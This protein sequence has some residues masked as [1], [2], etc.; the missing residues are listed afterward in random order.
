MSS[1]GPLIDAEDLRKNVNGVVLGSMPES[2]TWDSKLVIC[3]TTRHGRV[4]GDSSSKLSTATVSPAAASTA[5]RS[6]NS[7]A[8]VVAVVAIL[9]APSGVLTHQPSEVRRMDVLMSGQLSVGR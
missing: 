9:T 3:A 8:V 6:A 1:N 5:A 2:L 4:T 7:C